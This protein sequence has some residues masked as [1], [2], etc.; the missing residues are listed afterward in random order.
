MGTAAKVV[1][2]LFGIIF[3]LG[4]FLFLFSTVPLLGLIGMIIG[5][6]LCITGHKAGGG[7]LN[8][9]DEERLRRGGWWYYNFGPGKKR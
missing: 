4:G 3:L 6:A 9:T 2:Y 8:I 1:C 5:I 7:S